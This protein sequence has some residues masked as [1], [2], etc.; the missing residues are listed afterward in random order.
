MEISMLP[1]YAVA[2]MIGAI[3]G[4]NVIWI[5][6]TSGGRTRNFVGEHFWARGYD[7]STVGADAEVV[8]TYIHPGSVAAHEDI[9]PPGR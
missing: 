3:K 9:R 4:K 8:R 5:A 6:R 7:V 1:K 2:R